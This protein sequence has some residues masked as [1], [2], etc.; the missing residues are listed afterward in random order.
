MRQRTTA[1]AHCGGARV[2][3]ARQE[4]PKAVT[5][6]K[7]AIGFLIRPSLPRP[8][9]VHAERNVKGRVEP[10]TGPHRLRGNTLAQKSEMSLIVAA[11]NFP[12]A[13]GALP[14]LPSPP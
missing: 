10:S 12:P 13:R 2:V 4:S 9:E 8:R 6:R 3:F 5:E 14:V 7:H 11:A 1:V